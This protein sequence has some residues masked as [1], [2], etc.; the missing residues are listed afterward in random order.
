M[1]RLL[2][3]KFN[4]LKNIKDPPE[5]MIIID[6]TCV[7]GRDFKTC[8]TNCR[9]PSIAV[10][11][12]WGAGCWAWRGELGRERG[13]R[14]TWLVTSDS[15][16]LIC[17]MPSVATESLRAT[18]RRERVATTAKQMA[19]RDIPVVFHHINFTPVPPVFFFFQ[20]MWQ[21]GDGVGKRGRA[22]MGKKKRKR[23][24]WR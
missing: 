6:H 24:W 15:C 11:K 7:Q 22:G 17:S 14:C 20:K 4:S 10:T 12:F 19:H 5:E 8:Q 23:G 16:W 21:D 2:L 1:R 3:Y 9:K 13:Q 18:L